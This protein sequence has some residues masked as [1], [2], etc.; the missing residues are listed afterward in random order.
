LGLLLLL[1]LLLP[2]LLPLLFHRDVRGPA[3][4]I[5]LNRRL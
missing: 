4:A 3:I 5:E 1:L 2:L